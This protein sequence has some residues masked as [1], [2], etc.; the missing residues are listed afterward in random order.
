MR[1]TVALLAAFAALAVAPLASAQDFDADAEGA[2]LDRINALR[3]EQQLPALARSP[4]LDAAARG[5]SAEMADTGEL[6]HVSDRTG[7]PDDRVRAVGVS[8]GAVTENVAFHHDGARAQEALLA[9]A[10]HRANM[11]NGDTT[12][13]GLGVVRTERGVY[14]TQIF[15]QVPEAPPAVAE[16]P[17]EAPAT[18]A[19][20]TPAPEADGPR[21]GII[22]PFLQ[23]AAEAAVDTVAP[24]AAR[25]AGAPSPEANE[26]NEA[27]E[28]ADANPEAAAAPA[29]AAAQAEPTEPAPA[30][31]TAQAEPTEAAPGEA[32][33]D[34]AGA[35]VTPDTART[36]RT[37]VGL[38]QSLL[39]ARAEAPAAE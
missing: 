19:E 33:T 8:A 10:P 20:Q 14:V 27:N 37:L 13:A 1:R 23:R 17:A 29:E 24:G 3:A 18:A 34:R 31:A 7:T 16:A 6:T 28:A 15:A 21:Y 39:G 11:L 35:A 30:E 32:S 26:A 22:P 2:M 25:S 5:H 4:E 38:A 9:S 12:H 36:L